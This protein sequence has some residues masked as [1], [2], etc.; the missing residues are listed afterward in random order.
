MKLEE[1]VELIKDDGELDSLIKEAPMS[2]DKLQLQQAFLNILIN[3]RFAM[4]DVSDDKMRLEIELNEGI[5]FATKCKTMKIDEK[6]NLKDFYCV[7][8]S[9]FGEGMNKETMKR[10]FDPFFTTKALGEGTGMG[11]AMVYGTVSN[12]NGVL[13]VE[14]KQGKGTTF[15][16]F[17]PKTTNEKSVPV[18]D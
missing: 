12:H 8:I 17:L 2:G 7:R 6:I 14:S 16:V 18:K 3:A 15:N 13:R 1:R 9:D 11:L 5:V 10:I 4:R